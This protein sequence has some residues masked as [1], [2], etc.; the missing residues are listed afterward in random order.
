M[1][2]NRGAVHFG[3]VLPQF[4]AS[5]AQAREV[6]QA[7]DESGFDSVWVV[8]HLIS[9]LNEAETV[10]EAWTEITAIG[11][12]T[13]R[14]R[15]GQIVLCVS[16]RHPP[17]LAKMAATL[18]QVTGGRLIVGLGAGWHSGEYEQYGYAYPPIGTRLRQLDEACQILRRLWSEERTTFEGR[19]FQVRNAQLSPKPAQ[20]RLPI[21]IGG[22]G[23]KVM[24]RLV[25]E[26]AD[27]WNNLGAYHG[28]AAHKR[29]VL[30]EHCR[31]IGRDPAEI[32]VTQQT[33]AAIAM[34]RTDAARRTEKVVAELG[35]LDATP[36][37]ALTGTP[38]EIRTRVEKNRALGINGFMMSFGRRTDPEHVRLFAREV[39]SAYR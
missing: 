17:L 20:P 11:A 1:A 8:D 3:V 34:D 27:I 5:F 26:H 37:L 16:F 2:T 19:H 9:V 22:G 13:Q 31:A 38:E 10:L 14:V 30:R 28:D 33:L 36:E 23:E 4:N 21:M 29:E 32:L 15:I 12:I 24:L 18:D 6:A 7:A 39:V 25:A 35:F